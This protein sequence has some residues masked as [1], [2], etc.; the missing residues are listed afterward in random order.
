MASIGII[1]RRI[2]TLNDFKL[3]V[4]IYRSILNRDDK[5]L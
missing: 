2:F 5:I 1:I 3:G 4:K